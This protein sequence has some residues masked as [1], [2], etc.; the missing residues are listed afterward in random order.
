MTKPQNLLNLNNLHNSFGSEVLD[1]HYKKY[2]SAKLKG[3]EVFTLRRF[4]EVI[5]D[6]SML[7]GFHVG[8]TIDKIG[9]EFDLL[10]ITDENVLNIEFKS[11]FNL[12]KIQK[13]QRKNHYY[14]KALE[15]NLIIL[16]FE[17]ENKN[18]Y[19]L[20][21]D[22][23]VLITVEEINEILKSVEQHEPFNNLDNLFE[24]SKYLISP[25]NQSDRFLNSEYFLTDQQ[26][27][28]KKQIRNYNKLIQI[29][30]GNP[31]TGKTLLLYDLIK[32]AI[33]DDKK[34]MTVHCGELNEGHKYI[35]ANN[36]WDIRSP[37][38]SWI[39]RDEEFEELEIIFL[40]E[41]QRL[42]PYQLDK[43]IDAARVNGIKL[44][45]SLDPRQYLRSNEENFRNYEKLL[46]LSDSVSVYK[47]S[48]KIR[49]NRELASFTKC[50][51]SGENYWNINYES[52]SI[53]YLDNQDDFEKI[54]RDLER[55]G[56]NYLE[57]THS[58]YTKGITYQK[59]TYNLYQSK[60]SHR[61]IGQE[62]DKV[63]IVLD[64]S[65][66]LDD[67]GDFIVYN[68]PSYYDTRQMLYQN[69]TRA[70]DQIKFIIYNNPKLYEKLLRIITN[71]KE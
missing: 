22:E 27:E 20:H 54:I 3:S 59:F 45:V 38:R 11:T 30:K 2:D 46:N 35:I 25:F 9:K 18:I 67:E 7:D 31:G 29:I 33:E 15:K 4:I 28:F 69:I 42:Y 57:Y 62:F 6:Y 49:T 12:E 13:Q 40:D 16:T 14:L 23:S 34:I 68:G 44:V 71:T 48:Q 5:N 36:K 56:W 53:D 41:A 52:I 37:H 63:V 21:N 51:F 24:P 32:E 65:F 64:E 61:V 60:N 26:V 55:I 70:R 43:I 50:I 1:L 17:A 58:R 19:K 66:S 8:Y 47:L 39:E 10:K